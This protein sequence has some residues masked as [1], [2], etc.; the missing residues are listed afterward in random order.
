MRL[1]ITKLSL[2]IFHIANHMAQDI[3]GQSKI[4]FPRHAKKYRDFNKELNKLQK[5]RISAFK[6]FKIDVKNNKF[7]IKKNSIYA[8][9]IEL[10]NFKKLLKK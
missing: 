7:P 9:K 10:N 8:S 1:V 5:E 2:M 6:E 4:K 3:L